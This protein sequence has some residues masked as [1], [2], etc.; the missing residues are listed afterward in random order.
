M[1]PTTFETRYADADQLLRSAE[2]EMNRSEE[3][4]VPQLIAHNSREAIVH[5]LHGFLVQYAHPITNTDS[6]SEL[7]R[8]CQALDRRFGAIDL[9][10]ECVSENAENNVP[11]ELDA[12]ANC[13][14]LAKQIREIA[15]S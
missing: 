15:L 3:D 10:A 6:I 11:M 13:F 14:R 7:L 1:L 2:D 9:Q 5:Y 8:S 4:A 12:V